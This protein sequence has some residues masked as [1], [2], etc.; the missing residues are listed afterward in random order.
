MQNVAQSAFKSDLQRRVDLYVWQ[1]PL[2]ASQQRKSKGEGATPTHHLC[3]FV[4]KYQM[5]PQKQEQRKPKY[6]SAG[7][8]KQNTGLLVEMM[9]KKSHLVGK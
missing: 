1:I 6:L 8:P 4:P 3:V 2:G 7:D 5:V 9:P